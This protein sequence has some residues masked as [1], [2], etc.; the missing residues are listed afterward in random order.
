MRAGGC[1]YGESVAVLRSF[2]DG[3]ESLY[4]VL[5]GLLA[6][7]TG[8]NIVNARKFDVSGG[9]KLRV[10][11]RMVFAQ[12]P[13]AQHCDTWLIEGV[14]DWPGIHSGHIVAESAGVYNRPLFET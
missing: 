4:A 12:R 2:L 14:F 6:G 1:D 8:G 5:V 13:G 11:S 7:G 3:G 9:G 10:D